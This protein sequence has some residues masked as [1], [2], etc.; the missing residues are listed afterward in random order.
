MDKTVIEKNKTSIFKGLTAV[1][2]V[3]EETISD[4]GH[5]VVATKT[6]A[7]NKAIIQYVSKAICLILMCGNNNIDRVIPTNVRPEIIIVATIQTIIM[8][9]LFIKT[10]KKRIF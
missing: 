3:Q 4:N 6:T 2:L 1:L 9:F 7:P 8:N 5:S 10:I